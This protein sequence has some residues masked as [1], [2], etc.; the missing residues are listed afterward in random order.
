MQTDSLYSELLLTVSQL[1]SNPALCSNVPKDTPNVFTQTV[2]L[3]AILNVCVCMRMRVH[4]F[5][6]SLYVCVQTQVACIHMHVTAR[7]QTV[8]LSLRHYSHC[9]ETLVWES[10]SRLGREVGH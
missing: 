9:I 3:V 8:L 7:D 10:P 6:L 4:L 2:C 1:V 5:V